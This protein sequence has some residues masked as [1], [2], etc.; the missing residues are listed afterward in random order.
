MGHQKGRQ[1]IL[2]RGKIVNIKIRRSENLQLKLFWVDKKNII[3]MCFLDD[4]G[5]IMIIFISDDL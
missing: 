5:Q 4:Y 3:C 2:G 1:I